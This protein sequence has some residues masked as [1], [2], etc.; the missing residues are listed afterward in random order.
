[1]VLCCAAEDDVRGLIYDHLP[2]PSEFEPTKARLKHMVIIGHTTDTTS[3]I[4]AKVPTLGTW[5][6]VLST[7]KIGPTLVEEEDCI[8]Q[9]HNFEN[10]DVLNH[11]FDF[12]NLMAD[13]RYYYVLVEGSGIDAIKT[14]G[15]PPV[16]GG[17]DGTKGGGQE[18]FR[19]AKTDCHAITFA[20][21]SCHDPYSWEA[22]KAVEGAWSQLA[23]VKDRLDLTIGGGDQVSVG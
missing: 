3:R 8:V 10:G 6:V 9:T 21:Y 17:A 1:M 22:G 23:D 2:T 5:S 4:W 14:E 19:T 15:P 13:T 18:Y 16:I 20:A 12:A 7:K 11:C